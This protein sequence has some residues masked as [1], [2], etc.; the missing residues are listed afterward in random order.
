MK[1]FRSQTNEMPKEMPKVFTFSLHLLKS[2]LLT[3]FSCFLR[4]KVPRYKRMSKTWPKRF[5]LTKSPLPEESKDTLC[6]NWFSIYVAAALSFVGTVQFSLYFSSIWPYLQ[7][8]DRSI[9]ETQFGW[10]IAIYSVGQ[11]V[12]A[13]LFGFLSNKICQVR[14]PLIIGLCLMFLG[15]VSYLCLEIV[16]LPKFYI[17][18]FCRCIV[19]MGSGNVCLLRTYAS[20]ASTVKDRSR[21]IAFVTC[22]Q[23]LGATSGPAFQLLFT[24]ISYPG[25]SLF[26]P[27]NFNLY[28]AP[29]YLACLMNIAGVIVLIMCFEEY[30]AGLEEAKAK[31]C[32][33]DKEKNAENEQQQKQAK[34]PPYDL[35]ACLV[36][37]LSRFTQMFVQGNLETIGSPYAMM[38]FAWSEQIA[39]QVTAIAQSLVGAITF[40]TYILYISLKSKKELNCRLSCILSFVG[41]IIFHLIT[42]SW[43][44]L[45]TPVTT[46]NETQSQ[47]EP[48]PVGCNATKFSWCQNLSQVNVWLFY[49]S[50]VV[51]IGLAF[52]VLNI[53]MNTLFS[54]I[55]GPRRQGTQQGFFQIS[56]TFARLIGPVLMSNLYTLRGPNLA[57]TME[58]AVAGAT[59]FMWLI[60]YGRMVPLLTTKRRSLSA[61]TSF[62]RL[63]DGKLSTSG[64]MQSIGE[65]EAEKE[66]DQQRTEEANNENG[67][68]N[69]GTKAEPIRRHNT[70]SKTL[71]VVLERDGKL[72][73]AH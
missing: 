60:F 29:A 23:A 13:P 12:S 18:L 15:N 51:C 53:A 26:G 6:T 8:I 20:T 42:F 47:M 37:Y 34:L 50:Y 71:A 72:S 39:V 36:C 66:S 67:K 1:M 33:G 35:L 4:I 40:G 62:S 54:H 64:S 17:L 31:E 10:V 11:I 48:R 7:I 55:L 16:Q 30:Y 28:T 69:G 2:F 56:G 5:S 59:L 57:W 65:E 3:F 25:F 58:L 49:S 22:G 44:F 45:P 41:L 73:V 21:A 27:L 38:M 9:D 19:G 46:F 14:L 68:N 61:A 63:E 24:F 43:P 70:L 32:C 52:P